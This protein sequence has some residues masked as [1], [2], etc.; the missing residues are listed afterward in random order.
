M[1]RWSINSNEVVAAVREQGSHPITDLRHLHDELCVKL[2][3]QFAEL[4]TFIA[5]AML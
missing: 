5:E 2:D 4:S 1:G 3:D